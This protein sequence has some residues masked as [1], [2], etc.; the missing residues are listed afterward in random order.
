[1]A[2]PK[3]VTEDGFE[4]HFGTNHLGHFLLFQLLKPALLASSTGAFNSRVVSL[5]SLG[6]RF[7]TIS[8]DDFHFSKSEYDPWKAYGQSKLANIHFANELERRYGS[9]GLHALSVHPGYITTALQ[10]H[11]DYEKLG[12][13]SVEPRLLKSP[14]QGAATTV[15]AA[16]SKDWEGRGGRYL[17]DCSEAAPAAADDLYAPGYTEKAYDV[18]TEKRLWVESLKMAGLLDDNSVSKEEI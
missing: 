4:T 10:R 16:V 14:Q 1:M 2:C 12:F 18:P 17:E 3:G 11:V 9:S 6:Y 15:W 5:T 13:D 7:G 8:F